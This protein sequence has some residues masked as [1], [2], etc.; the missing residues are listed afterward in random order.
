MELGSERDQMLSC[1][2]LRVLSNIGL[3]QREAD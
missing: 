3:G 2:G 1:E